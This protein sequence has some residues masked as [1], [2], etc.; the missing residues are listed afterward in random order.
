MS[1]QSTKELSATL[2]PRAPNTEKHRAV[3]IAPLNKYKYQIYSLA[4]L[5]ETSLAQLERDVN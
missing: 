1:G 4:V 2:P 5:D 3:L